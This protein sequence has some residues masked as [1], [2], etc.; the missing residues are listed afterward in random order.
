MKSSRE[1]S[2][3]EIPLTQIQL[4][5]NEYFLLNNNDALTQS[6]SWKKE[7]STITEDQ[8]KEIA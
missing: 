3:T 5:I 4:S 6:D 7:L 8:Q 2:I 1:E